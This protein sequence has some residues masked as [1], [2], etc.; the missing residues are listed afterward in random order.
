[1]I[2]SVLISNRIYYLDNDMFVY[3]YL[4]L[5]LLSFASFCKLRDDSKNEYSSSVNGVAVIS[6]GV[7]EFCR[8]EFCRAE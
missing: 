8:E 6:F 1:M 4:E 3:L 2:D 7:E 5:V